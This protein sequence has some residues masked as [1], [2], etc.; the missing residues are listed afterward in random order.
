MD[1]VI[2]G[3]F[4]PIEKA[5]T[6]EEALKALVDNSTDFNRPFLGQPHTLN[7]ERG[8][9]MVSGLRMRD[10]RDCLHK[11][12]WKEA[13]ELIDMEALAQNL[14]C[15]IEKAMG[16]YPNVPKLVVTEQEIEQ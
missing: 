13:G 16:I 1:N 2:S 3:C 9:Q 4:T 10:I 14:L 8:K 7:G 6:L 12:K 11:A 5:K 15:E